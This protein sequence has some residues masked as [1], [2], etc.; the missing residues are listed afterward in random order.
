MKKIYLLGTLLLS[1]LLCQTA[2]AQ[3][4]ITAAVEN[5]PEKLLVCQ[6]SYSFL[7]KTGTGNYEYWA[8]T[9]NQFD[10]HYTTLYLGNSFDSAIQTLSDLASLMK[11]EVAGVNVQQ[12]DGNVILTF[13]K[14]LGVRMLWIKQDG[15]GGKS[16]ISL[17]IVEKMIKYFEEQKKL[18][19]S[20]NEP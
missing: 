17:P 8:R 13:A 4:N 19:Q 2:H 9:D 15:Q 16:W 3:L 18:E 14:Q 5:K 6:V 12:E 11:K 10:T 7:Y 1:V 20:E